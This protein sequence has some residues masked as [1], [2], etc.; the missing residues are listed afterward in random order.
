[1][2]QGLFQIVVAAESTEDIQVVEDTLVSGSDF[3]LVQKFAG[4]LN[5]LKLALAL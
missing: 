5:V 4:F 2:D 1:M 3:A